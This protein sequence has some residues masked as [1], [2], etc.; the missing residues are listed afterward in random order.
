M[1]T[2]KLVVALVFLTMLA[3]AS[4]FADSRPRNET[5]R[6]RP[7][8]RFESRRNDRR[9]SI[10]AEGRIRSINR[11]QD[12]Y[13]VQL[14]RGSYR[15]YL[16]Q[17]S[18]RAARG[19]GIR[20][21]RVGMGIRLHG[22]LERGNWVRVSSWDWLDGYDRRYGYGYDRTVSGIVHRI[23]FRRGRLVLRE[24]FNRRLVT[25][26]MARTSRRRSA[27]LAE[28]RRGDRVTLSGEWTRSGVFRASRIESVRSA[29]F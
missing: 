12:G 21:L 1:K 9:R 3:A 4:T 7:N 27:D 26:D 20:D 18:Y 5:W 19:R 11:H 29:R 6:D 16:P 17:Q 10:T 24:A 23:D 8:D 15:F 14:D 22:W 28:L 13:R 2:G 25:V